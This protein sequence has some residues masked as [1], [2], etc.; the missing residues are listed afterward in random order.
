MADRTPL[1]D[2]YCK[3]V[4]CHWRRGNKCT[5]AYCMRPGNEKR[6]TYF[7]KLDKLAGGDVPE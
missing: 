2:K 1:N 5:V 6:A 7:A 3:E 4:N